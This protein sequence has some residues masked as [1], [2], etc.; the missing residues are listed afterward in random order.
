MNI[1]Y[2]GAEVGVA[3]TYYRVTLPASYLESHGHVVRTDYF[4]RHSS[5]KGASTVR[6]P[7]GEYTDFAVLS[8]GRFWA[9]DFIESITPLREKGVKIHYDIDDLNWHIS[10]SNP[11]Y[12]IMQKAETSRQIKTIIKNVDLV[13][14]TTSA[15][16]NEVRKANPRS[17]VV[18]PNYIEDLTKYVSPKEIDKTVTIGLTGGTSH[19]NDWRLVQILLSQLCAEYTNLRVIIGGFDH[20]YKTLFEP[21]LPSDRVEFFKW[22]PMPEYAKWLNKCDI[23]LVPL[24][25]TLFDKCKSHLKAIE[26]MCLGKC[27]IVSPHYSSVIEH[28]VN[29]YIAQKNRHIN[30]LKACRSLIESQELREQMGL[31]ARKVVLDHWLIDKNGWRWEKSFQELSV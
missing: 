30:W 7:I 12:Q 28:Q 19:L 10:P 2:A 11:A 14:V 15:L 4:V 22:V 3:P 27:V 26:A 31:K 24:G 13:T 20:A 8:T 6:I 25:D 16:A 17:L 9:D 5:E 23:I 18:I 21:N 29:G 1:V